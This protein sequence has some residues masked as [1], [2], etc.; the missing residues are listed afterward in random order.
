[1]G[2]KDKLNQFNDAIDQSEEYFRDKDD[3][4]ENESEEYYPQE[5][6]KPP[7]Y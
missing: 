2:M 6:L 5:T 3:Y 4:Y 1:M 7:H